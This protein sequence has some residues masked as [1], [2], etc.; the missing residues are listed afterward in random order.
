MASSQML[1]RSQSASL[2][3]RASENIVAL[4]PAATASLLIPA[5]PN[6]SRSTGLPMITP[7]EPVIVP[8]WVT[9]TSAGAEMK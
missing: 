5:R 3:G 8:G 4:D 7:M 2:N 1:I 6:S 9:I